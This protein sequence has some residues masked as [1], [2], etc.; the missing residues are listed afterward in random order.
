MA[1]MH[2][3]T[4]LLTPCGVRFGM[5]GGAEK[6]PAPTLFVFAKS[7]EES[8]SEDDYFEIGRVVTPHGYRCV[9]LDMPCHGQDARQGEP[10]GLDGWR[11]RIESGEEVIAPFVRDLAAVLDYLIEEGWTDAAQVAA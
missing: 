3:S 1:E 5:T 11:A 10:H 2:T 4:I 8:L 7:L 9:S 6:A